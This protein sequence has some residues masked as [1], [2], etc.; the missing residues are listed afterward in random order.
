MS[1][2]TPGPWRYRYNPAGTR[3]HQIIA[4]DG[5]LVAV[6]KSGD[7]AEIIT[8]TPEL[9]KASRAALEPFEFAVDR[10]VHVYGESPNIDFILKMRREIANMKA[11]IAKAKGES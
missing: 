7:D 3:E 6:A 4:E 1:K 5:K 10:L 11:A 2:H 8:A 9:L